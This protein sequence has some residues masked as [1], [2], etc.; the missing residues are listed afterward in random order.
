MQVV[1]NIVDFGMSIEDAVASPRVHLDGSTF[2]LEPGMQDLRD[3]GQLEIERWQELNLFF[4]GVHCV[5]QRQDSLD[6]V[7]DPRRDGVGVVV[8]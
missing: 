2:S 1:S 6:A 7:G 8:D 4:G 5:E 3:P